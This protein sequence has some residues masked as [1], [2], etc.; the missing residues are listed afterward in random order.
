MAHTPALLTV[1]LLVALAGCTG[2]PPPTPTFTTTYAPAP[3]HGQALVL[4]DGMP[5][6][7]LNARAHA[8]NPGGARATMGVG[9]T[10]TP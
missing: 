6:T 5:V 7:V 3:Q 10:I 9:M 1:A 4:R 8:P 2:P